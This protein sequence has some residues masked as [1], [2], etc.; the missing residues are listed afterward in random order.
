MALFPKRGVDTSLPKGDRGF[1]SFD[2]YDFRLKPKN[3]QDVSQVRIL[4]H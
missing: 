3:A 1:A 2:D 4:S